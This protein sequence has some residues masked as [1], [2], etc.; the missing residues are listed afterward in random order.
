MRGSAAIRRALAA[1]RSLIKR[2]GH[3]VLP[4]RVIASQQCQ[5]SAVSRWAR[6]LRGE[7]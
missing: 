2:L 7:L 3:T 1:E 6:D 5:G 4:D